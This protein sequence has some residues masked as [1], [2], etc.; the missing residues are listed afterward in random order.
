MTWAVGLLWQEW[1]DSNVHTETNIDRVHCRVH[2]K[3]I[4]GFLHLSIILE[5]PCLWDHIMFSSHIK[6]SFN[7]KLFIQ[8]EIMHSVPW[9]HPIKKQNENLRGQQQPMRYQCIINQEYLQFWSLWLKTSNFFFWSICVYTGLKWFQKY[10][11]NKISSPGPWF[12]I[13]TSSYE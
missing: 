9:I 4:Q 6:Y 11:S 3:W 10:V 2:V 12:N 8:C 1:P 5:G 13:K 7:L